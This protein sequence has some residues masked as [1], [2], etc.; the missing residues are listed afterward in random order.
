MA[1]WNLWHGCR[2]ISEGCRH[3]YVYRMDAAHQRDAS[4]IKKNVSFDLPL[5]KNRVGEYK[6]PSGET[7]YTCFTSDF[8]L[9]EA[10]AWRPEVWRIMRTRSDLNFF[11]I[12]KRIHRA[13]ACFPPDWGEGYPNVT[14]CCTVENQ[15]CA[16]FRLPIYRDL[17]I[18]H[19]AIICEPLLGPIDLS[20]YL[21]KWA[22]FVLAGG[23]SGPD[24]RPCRYEW[25]LALREQAKRAGVGFRFKQTG[26][27]FIKDGRAYHIPR[28]LQHKQARRAGLD[29]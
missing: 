6:I 29:L 23:E 18:R 13:A 11:F 16:D 10:D 21:G 28:A 20:P 7:V 22:D 25:V 27:Y 5:R 19:K 15:N 3:C 9:E 26:T 4:E 2:K 1:G 8:F 24:A 14:I 12:T 17:S